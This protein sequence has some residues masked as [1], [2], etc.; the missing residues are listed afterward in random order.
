MDQLDIA[1]K[2]VKQQYWIEKSPMDSISNGFQ[3]NNGVAVKQ[4]GSKLLAPT[5]LVYIV[6]V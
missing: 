1:D 4:L 6:D 3:V 5:Y 2:V